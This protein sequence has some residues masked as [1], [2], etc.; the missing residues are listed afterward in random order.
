QIAPNNNYAQMLSNT[1]SMLQLSIS[2]TIAAQAS[3]N[4]HANG[5]GAAPSTM[6]DPLPPIELQRGVDGHVPPELQGD[7]RYQ[8]WLRCRQGQAASQA[9]AATPPNGGNPFYAP[10]S[11]P[12]PGGN[13]PTP[14]V[15]YHLPLTATDF[16]PAAYGHP[17]LEQ[18]LRSQPF[19][20]QQQ[21]GL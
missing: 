2:Q 9:P 4:A 3:T 20:P 5:S 7:P 19:N 8:A 15:Q 6:C 10:S 12:V 11:V 17:F 21:A 13:Y 14:V 1:N 18:Y 16:V